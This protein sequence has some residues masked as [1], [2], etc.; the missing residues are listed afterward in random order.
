MSKSPIEMIYDENCSDPIVLYNEDGKEVSFEQIALIPIEDKHYVILKPLNG[1]EE[2]AE[3]E[4]L[5]F[6]ITEYAGEEVLEIVDDDEII[7]DVFAEY[8]TLLAEEGVV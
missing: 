4:A 3:D 8:Y 7:D 1:F 6:V 2:L 5:V